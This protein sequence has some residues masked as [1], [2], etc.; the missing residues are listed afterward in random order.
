VTQDVQLYAVWG[1]TANTVYRTVTYHANIPSGANDSNV[2][3]PSP[4][5]IPNIPDGTAQP[6]TAPTGVPTIAGGTYTFLGWSEN[7]SATSATYTTSIPTVTKDFALYAIWSFTPTGG[8]YVPPPPTPT[9][10]PTPDPDPDPTPDPDPDPDPTPTPDPT[11]DPEPTPTPTPTPQQ[12]NLPPPAPAFPGGTFVPDED[13][14]YIEYDEEGVPLGQWSWDDDEEVWVF[15]SYTPEGGAP[16]T[17][18]YG[19]AAALTLFV[20][21]AGAILITAT[22]R[23]KRRRGK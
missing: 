2:V 15:V 3:L 20:L 18:D 1:F 19:F 7:P 14:G 4:N 11:P 16:A 17:G 12:P 8:G 5:P 22:P 6:L 9:P 23:V 13:G 21:A 10:T